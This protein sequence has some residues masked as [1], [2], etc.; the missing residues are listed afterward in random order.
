[1]TVYVAPWRGFHCAIATASRIRR[2]RRAAPGVAEPRLQPHLDER[3]AARATALGGKQVRELALGRAGRLGRI[4][5]ERRDEA[6]VVQARNGPQAVAHRE[7][8]DLPR[9]R[10]AR[11]RRAHG[12]PPGRR[13]PALSPRRR[14]ALRAERAAADA[15]RALS[16]TRCWKAPP[17]WRTDSL[18][19][20]PGPKTTFTGFMRASRA[21]GPAE[22]AGRRRA[23]GEVARDAALE[24]EHA[25]EVLREQE[26]CQR[27]ADEH[28]DRVVAEA[29]AQRRRGGVGLAAL[30]D[31]R[32]DAGIGLQPQCAREAGEREHGRQRQHEHGPPGRERHSALQRASVRQGARRLAVCI[33]PV[34][35]ATDGVDALVAPKGRHRPIGATTQGGSQAEARPRPSLPDRCRS[36]SV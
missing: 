8:H 10:L 27:A 4:E 33:E 14:A 25:L 17:S 6:R 34:V 13:R 15:R 26:L 9:E 32:V 31:Q 28:D 29:L 18:M 1:M 22:P 19:N 12:P 35:Q 7:I 3:G 36:T 21:H 23:G 24:A 16:A 11:R 2:E 20:V 30:A 5:D